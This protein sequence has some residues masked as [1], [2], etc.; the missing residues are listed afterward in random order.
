[1][2]LTLATLVMQRPISILCP[3]AA[4][5][6]DAALSKSA[7]IHEAYV[8]KVLPFLAVWKVLLA[9]Q[10]RYASLKEMKILTT[11]FSLGE[12]RCMIACRI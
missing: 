4:I 11:T 2:R 7:S 1:M 8:H 12:Q 6:R 3:V 10:G 5:L 9:K